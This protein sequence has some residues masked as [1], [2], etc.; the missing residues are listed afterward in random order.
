MNNDRFKFR[1]WHT[2]KNQYICTQCD[3]LAIDHS[4]FTSIKTVPDIRGWY[5]TVL[6]KFYN[7]FELIPEQCTGLKDKNGKLIY[8]GDIVLYYWN[9]KTTTGVI[10][11]NDAFAGFYIMN[12]EEH[13]MESPHCLMYVVDTKNIEIIGNIHEQVKQK[14]I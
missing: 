6:D 1:Y 4:C 14:E 9:T 10:R 7:N 12:N 13:C 2:E 3:C 5:N 11:W 8:D